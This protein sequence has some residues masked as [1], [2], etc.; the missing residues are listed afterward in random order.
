MTERKREEAEK[1]RGGNLEKEMWSSE[2][3]ERE[4]ESPCE[5]NRKRKGKP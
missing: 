3:R 4:G 2:V 5:G 1:G